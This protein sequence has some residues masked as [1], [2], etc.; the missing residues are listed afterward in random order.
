MSLNFGSLLAVLAVLG[1]S[2]L[3]TGLWRREERQRRA[4]FHLSRPRIPLA[5]L[6]AQ[7]FGHLDEAE[8]IALLQQVAEI[9]GVEPMCL[10]PEDRFAVELRHLWLSPCDT[11]YD[12]ICD[13]YEMRRKGAG[14]ET[15]QYPTTVADYVTGIL[16]PGLLQQ[17]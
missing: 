15:G 11:Q 8:T 1:S 4:A 17:T 7:H 16:K 3:G 2:A 9:Y 5:E 6:H 14:R 12:T 13:T 10:R